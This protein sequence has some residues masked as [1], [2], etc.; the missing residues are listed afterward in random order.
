MISAKMASPGLLKIT[1][2]WNKGY[3]IIISVNDITNKILWHDSNHIVDVFMG[4]RF[5]N[6]RISMRE[7]ITASIL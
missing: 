3:D 1:V 7:V 4:P 6:S 5:G 2:F